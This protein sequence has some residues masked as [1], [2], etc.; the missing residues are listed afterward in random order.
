MERKMKAEDHVIAWIESSR[1][2]Y[3]RL[4]QLSEFRKSPSAPMHFSGLHVLESATRLVADAYR[5]MIRG[6]DALRS[7]PYSTDD[8]AKAVALVAVWELEQ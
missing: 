1:E 6:G 8:L 7:D 4:L 5:E 3:D 2:H